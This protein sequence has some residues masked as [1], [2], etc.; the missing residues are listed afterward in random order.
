MSRTLSDRARRSAQASQTGEVWLEM[1][2]IDHPS[3]PAALRLTNNTE[4]INSAGPGL[5]A[6]LS[7]SGNAGRLVNDPGFAIDP[8]RGRA[9]LRLGSAADQYVDVGDVLDFTGTDAFSVACYARLRAD[10]PSPFNYLVSKE[11]NAAPWAGWTLQLVRDDGRFLFQRLLGDNFERAW[12]TTLFSPERWTHLCGTYDGASLR[13]YV[14]GAL[15][16][17]EIA[18]GSAQPD[19]AN[20]LRFGKSAGTGDFVTNLDGDLAEVTIWNK[21]LSLGEVQ[22]LFAA[23]PLGDEAGLVGY[24]P[25]DDP[26][27]ESYPFELTLPGEEEERPPV[28]RVR[29]D[30]VDRRVLEAVRGLRR[31]QAPQVKVEVA[32]ASDPRTPEFSFSGLLLETVRGGALVI[33]G[34]LGVPGLGREAVP[35]DTFNDQNFPGLFR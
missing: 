25:L 29:I 23:P 9:A 1:I 33:E 34:D 21:A 4:P 13:L 18:S 7:A 16:S 35:H 3:L 6:D 10:L 26:P 30:N 12:S 27:F 15:E 2:T 22:A 5:T 20:A 14:D 17:G 11:K 31:D 24:W 28:G 32:L 19:I 8:L